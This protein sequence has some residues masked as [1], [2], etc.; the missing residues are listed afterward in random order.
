MTCYKCKGRD[1]DIIISVEGTH[2]QAHR[3]VLQELSPYFSALLSRWSS[4]NQ[5]IYTIHGVAPY[6]MNYII[7]YAYTKQIRITR[8]N[9]KDLLMAADYL[10]V[11]DVVRL[12]CK[13]LEKQ[14]CPHNCLDIWRFARR[15]SWH[16]L[17]V[18]AAI[19]AKMNLSCRIAC[20]V[21]RLNL[22]PHSSL[23]SVGVCSIRRC[24]NCYAWP[25]REEQ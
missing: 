23:D 4:P 6:I 17:C 21:P 10:L 15:Y 22:W 25:N 7:Q 2:F 24:Q 13:F 19:M 11:N 5:I 18:K 1:W 14:L 8:K 12:C 3:I 9:V 16:K 20:S